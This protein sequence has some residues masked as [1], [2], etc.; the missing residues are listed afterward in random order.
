MWTWIGG[1][2]NIDLYGSI[3]TRGLESTNNK[4]ISVLGHAIF[5]G[6]NPLRLYI[7]G[8]SGYS[9]SLISGATSRF[10]GRYNP[11][12]LHKLDIG[13]LFNHIVLR[14]RPIG[15]TTHSSVN[16]APQTCSPRTWTVCSLVSPALL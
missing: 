11:L 1:Q 14:A 2:T 8:G 12:K 10:Q 3:G 16:L 5:A 9:S 15:I 6:D 7:W 4:L 13:E